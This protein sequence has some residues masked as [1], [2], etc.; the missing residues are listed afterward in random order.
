MSALQRARGNAWKKP[1]GADFESFF[2]FRRQGRIGHGG[3]LVEDDTL[4]MIVRAEVQKALNG[5]KHRQRRALGSHH[6]HHRAVRH[7]SHLVGA[8]LGTGEPGAVVV[9]HDAL[10]DADVPVGAVF[11][12]QETQGVG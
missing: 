10:N 9:A 5:G 1:K 2:N 3:A 7:L 6:Q 8:A 11:R 4:D 12:Q